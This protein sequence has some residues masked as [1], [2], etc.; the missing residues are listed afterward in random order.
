MTLPTFAALVALAQFGAAAADPAR[1][2]VPAADVARARELV[3]RLGSDSYADRERATR[4]LAE[5]G[6][7]AAGPLRAAL[8]D[9]DPEIAARAAGLYPPAAAAD[10]A[11]RA[12]AFAADRA[13]RYDHD[14]PGWE[15]FWAAAGDDPAARSLFL[16][17]VREPANAELLVAIGGPAGRGAAAAVAGGVV[18]GRPPVPPRPA[19]LVAPLARRRSAM[20]AA[21]QS[22]PP[23]VKPAGVSPTPDVALVLLAESL[24]PAAPPGGYAQFQSGSYFYNAEGRD[25]MVGKGPFGPVPARLAVRWLDTR[26]D[27]PAQYAA[28]L[29]AQNAGLGPAAGRYAVRYLRAKGGN[30]YNRVSAMQALVRYPDPGGVPA[31]EGYF[32]D[33]TA[34]VPGVPAQRQA[35]IRLRDA[36]LVAALVLTGQDPTAY[37]LSRPS[38]M[39]GGAAIQFP[40]ATYVFQDDAPGTAADKREAAFAR[41]RAWRAAVH[42]AVGGGAILPALPAKN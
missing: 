30:L 2:A 32:A 36:A 39:A 17:I 9:P 20:F 16:A 35:E 10:L 1:L 24:A 3:R 27:P 5:M 7:R 22:P 29:I 11:A 12:A 13:G 15:A 37:G 25:V 14:L 38:A 23:G 21:L 18:Y 31:L 4:D 26:A 19:D 28:I 40:N 41:W 33:E 42:G 8:A 34:V 6:R